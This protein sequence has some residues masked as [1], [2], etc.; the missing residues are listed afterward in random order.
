MT[1]DAFN[2][3]TPHPA[4]P[5][6][7]RALEDRF[8]R[9]LMEDAIPFQRVA[10]RFGRSAVALTVYCTSEQELDIVTQLPTSFEGFPV[11][12]LVT[13]QIAAQHGE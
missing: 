1:H 2:P 4:S 3:E 13:G 11:R 6:E 9:Q 8:E 12:T 5:D 7:R 10:L